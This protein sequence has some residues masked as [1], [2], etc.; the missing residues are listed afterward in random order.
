MAKVAGRARPPR[1]VPPRE[2]GRSHPASPAPSPGPS[3]R[4]SPLTM[5]APLRTPRALQLPGADLNLPSRAPAPAETASRAGAAGQQAP[6][7]RGRAPEPDWR[8]RDAIGSARS[9]APEAEGKPGLTHRR[10]AGPGTGPG[11]RMWE[12]G[13]GDHPR[14]P[15]A[16][17]S[18]ARVRGSSLALPAEAPRSGGTGAPRGLRSARR[19]S[20][21]RGL[22]HWPSRSPE[23]GRHPQRAPSPPSSAS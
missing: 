16:N 22:G 10:A 4:R 1:P 3:P 15:R 19:P 23:C 8:G 17:L 13:T 20:L 14:P 6:G 12:A 2:S 18:P 5:L 11:P 7:K 21:A 9:P